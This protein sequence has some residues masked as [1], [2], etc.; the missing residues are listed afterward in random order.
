M[1]RLLCIAASAFLSLTMLAALPARL[2]AQAATATVLGTVTDQSGAAVPG[3]AVDVKNTATGVSQ[4]AISDARGRYRVSNVP[5][6]LYEV[7]AELQGFQTALHKDVEV[8]VGSERVV[9]FVLSVGQV[10]ETVTVSQQVPLVETT[11]A[12]LSNLVDQTQIRELPLNGRNVE[13]LILLAPGV[14]IY[15]SI[16]AGA[17]YGSAPAYSVSG[18]RPNGQA[19][20]LDGTNIQDY[21]NRGSGAGVI[22]T[23]MGVDA[24]A[25]FQVL[26]N[27]YSAQYGGNGSVMNAVSKSGSNRFSGS[28]FEFLRNS[29]MDSK[30]YFDR[31]DQPI[32]PFRRD[33]FGFS[34]GGP[35]KRDRMFVF[36]NYEGLQQSLTQTRIITVPDANARQGLLP[37]GPGGSLVNVGVDPRVA[38]YF[39]FWPLPDTVIGG[40]LGNA[41]LTPKQTAHENYVLGR[42][43]WTPRD[44]DTLFARYVSDVAELF[45]PTGGPIPDLWP[46]INSNNN[47]FA[48]VEERHVLSNSKLNLVRAAFSRPWQR[49][50]TDINVH[51]EL[52]WFA[53]EGL[54]DGGLTIGGGVTGLGSAAPGPWQFSQS[55][56]NVSD[57]FYWTRG[58]HSLKFGAGAT[59]VNS[60][61]FSPIPGHGSFTFS[62]LTLFLQGVALQY[63]GTQRGGR[64]ATRNFREWL[65]DLY[66]QDDWQISNRLTLNLGLRYS[67]TNNGTEANDKLHR[68]ID[69]PVSTG[70]EAVSNIYD[71]NPSLSNLDPRIGVAWDPRADHRTSIRGGFGVYHAII[72]PRDYA[73]TYYNSPP[74]VTAVELNPVFPFPLSTVAPALPT[75]TFAMDMKNDL[76]TPYVEQWN[77]NLQQ[78]LPRN[79]VVTAAYVGSYSGDQVQQIQLNPPTPISTPNGLQFATLQTV[80]GRLTV[81]DNPRLNPAYDNLSSARTIGWAKYHSMQLGVN[82]RFANNWS[83][84]VSYTY[85]KC[86]DIGSGSFLVDGGTTLSNPFNPD[87]DEGACSYDLRHNLTL[88]GLYVLPFK[89]NA[90]VEGWQ[91]S[92]V[93]LVHSGNPFT[94]TTG[95]ANN[96]FRGSA[97]RPNLVSGCDPL[98]NSTVDHWFNA[99]CF[100]LP[101]VGFNGSYP[102]NALTGP[103]LRNVDAA[104]TKTTRL[105]GQRSV[106][107]R[108]EVFN[109]L[110]R[111]NLSLPNGAAYAQGAIA[112]TGTINP[113]AGR[114]TSTR[115]TARQVQ[116]G[117]RFE[118]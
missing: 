34:L 56:V 47:Q 63:S 80:N 51:P 58:A 64:D 5:I 117:F 18:S 98:A 10:S 104:F 61:V 38:P 40:G 69:P 85:S 43:D 94:V 115:T 102:R 105:A 86:R 70:F 8:V 111:A 26:T 114:I 27:T 77:V 91:V 23:S 62:S 29:A 90:L 101:D 99:A 42:F 84:Q 21:F 55:R 110:N 19:Q 97:P 109:L 46:T 103:P 48:T 2:A 11:S 17:F 41:S 92:G 25:E 81:V 73:A 28:A 71:H 100:T 106:Q 74:F 116:L 50:R 49:S 113:N 59:K 20:L 82:R 83:G 76:H 33:Q 24:I 112:G 88:N 30:N 118:F 6:G 9:D 39:K 1:S 95:I 3:V 93:M 16:F 75:Q 7:K 22:G 31:K 79:M 37:T 65:Y 54:P 32:P 36:V 107:F 68:I 96:T 4:T 66:A 12:Q 87:D 15:Q 13:Q 57:D 44:G 67:P 89:G 35:L 53:N 60:D 52:Q 72:G 45:E 78:Q 108:L 14:S